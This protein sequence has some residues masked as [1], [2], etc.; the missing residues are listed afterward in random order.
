[1]LIL[2]DIEQ[3]SRFFSSLEHKASILGYLLSHFKTS[4]FKILKILEISKITELKTL[5]NN[6]NHLIVF[7]Q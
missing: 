6:S 7:Y 2:E 3:M 4:K 1:M 5:K